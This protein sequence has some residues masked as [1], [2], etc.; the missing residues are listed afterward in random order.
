ML[1]IASR[2]RSIVL[3]DE[4]ENGVFHTHHVGLW[5][6]ILALIK[7]YNGQIFATTH[8]YEWLEALVKAAGDKLDDIAL[9]RLE[10][11]DNGEPVLFQFEGETLKGAIKHGAEARGG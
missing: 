5:R 8:S 9:W 4:M 7:N 3:S 1:A 10:R 11:G 6:S 2:E